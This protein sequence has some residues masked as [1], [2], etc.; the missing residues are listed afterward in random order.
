[1]LFFKFYKF[2]W[3][4][5]VSVAA[6]K[7]T[8]QS[9]RIGNYEYQELVTPIVKSESDDRE[10]LGL[11]LSNKMRVLLISDPKTGSASANLDVAV[12]SIA[13]PKSMPGLAHFCEHLLFMG[14]KKYPKVNA[15]DE[16]LGLNGGTSNAYTFYD[17]TNYYFSVNH[18]SLEGALDRFSQF[19][20]S[21]LFSKEAVAKEANAVNSEYQ[22]EIQSD[23]LRI[24][25]V[26]K[27]TL[28]QSHPFSRFFTGTYD[29][30]YK[31]PKSKGIEPRQEIIK[32]YNKYYSANQ[33]R[34][35]VLGRESLDQL[36]NM[37]V[38]KFSNVRNSKIPRP[39]IPFSP[40]SKDDLGVEIDIIP[41]ENSQKL[42]MQ[43][44]LPSQ[45]KFYREKPSR[46]PSFFLSH[47]ST[48]SIMEYLKEVGW[49][50]SISS[51]LSD[52]NIDFSILDVSLEL[53]TLGLENKYTIAQLIL[54]YAK[55]IK[56]N[57][58][59][60]KYFDEIASIDKI[61]FRFQERTDPEDYTSE[62]ASAMRSPIPLSEI[63]SSQ[64][65]MTRFDPELTQEMLGYIRKDNLRLS[66]V[67]KFTN[68]QLKEPWFGTKYSIKKLPQLKPT[69]IK[70]QLP[71]PN[72]YIPNNF[73]LINTNPHMQMLRNKSQGILWYAG[74]PTKTPKVYIYMLLK[75]NMAS[76]SSN[77][78][79][80]MDLMAGI[81]EMQL[82]A[83]EYNAKL[84]G[85]DYSINPSSSG[86]LLKFSGYNHKIEEFTLKVLNL[87]KNIELSES[88]FKVYK[89]KLMQDKKNAQFIDPLKHALQLI[90]V[91]LV[92]NTWAQETLLLSLAPIS[93][94]QLSKFTKYLLSSAKMEMLVV[95]NM[96]EGSAKRIMEASQD[97]LQ[98]K[99]PS[100]V[101]LHPTRSV[102]LPHGNFVTQMNMKNKEEVNS[103]IVFYI[104]IYAYNDLIARVSTKLVVQI[105]SGFASEQLRTQEQLGYIVKAQMEEMNSRGGLTILIQSERDPVYLESRIEAML[106]NFYR[107]VEAM[108]SKEFLQYKNAIKSSVLEKQRNLQET[109][110]F[111]WETINSGF[112]DFSQGIEIMNI[113]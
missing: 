13:D 26:Q 103:A 57:A 63:L 9:K 31:I 50:T 21:P 41:V 82:K 36:K 70:L 80:K 67:A 53:T 1:M 18:G 96:D 22:G 27:Y 93:H 62:L 99:L 2:G 59:T 105:L 23:M 24:D 17:H 10:Y 40:F 56:D 60:K 68:A 83:F 71:P 39:S 19:F 76:R 89:D 74:N 11:V 112:Y 58:I 5:L 55:L 29:T 46:L 52:E 14:T 51:E 94:P 79:V 88:S 37:T 7:D 16:Y 61:D 3:W 34:L 87:I 47:E 75:N 98:L 28:N 12:G 49:A 102:V 32:Y 78:N 101:F 100:N 25:L 106:E 66:V 30:L 4:A 20:I 97:V 91:A 113:Y 48:G 6:A 77:L 33:M 15:Y 104:E 69:G 38:S 43:F 45:A 110:D 95:G 81:V 107:L 109:T 73:D 90:A 42:I 111:Y 72:T 84:A 92:E 64:S 65:L 86:L 8:F 44:P 35:V 54:E 108:S 85:L